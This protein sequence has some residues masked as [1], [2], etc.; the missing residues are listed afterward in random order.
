MQIQADRFLALTAML[1]GFVP[2]GAEPQEGAPAEQVED[3]APAPAVQRP[4]EVREARGGRSPRPD[5][6]DVR[7]GG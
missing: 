3:A 7:R 5:G 6:D 4:V 2:T 1:A